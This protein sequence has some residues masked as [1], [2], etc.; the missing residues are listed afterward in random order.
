VNQILKDDSLSPDKNLPSLSTVWRYS[1]AE[2]LIKKLRPKQRDD[3]SPLPSSVLA[4]DRKYNKEIRSFEVEYVG[5]L[6]HLDFHTGS[7]RVITE[8][9]TWRSIELM[10]TIDDASR[11][12]CHAQWFYSE[13][14][15]TLIHGLTQG[16]Q[17]R[18][19]P[20]AI[21]MDNGSAMTSEEVTN[22]LKRIGVTQDFTLP[23]LRVR[24]F[25]S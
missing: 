21:M 6:W 1:K 22:G 2:G 13:T 17:K 19:L 25:P 14:A 12:V 15:E 10:T 20:R 11:F 16:F 5:G 9:G 18:G 24:S 23:Y 7:R 3:G 8:D 4:L